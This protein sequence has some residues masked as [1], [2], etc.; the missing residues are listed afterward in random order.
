M[1]VA[2]S[3]DQEHKHYVQD[4]LHK[5]SVDLIQWIDQG[6]HLYVCGD[7]SRMAK[8]VHQALIEI[9]SRV[10]NVDAGAAELELKQ[11]KRAGRYQ[12]DIY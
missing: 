11:L 8:D 5:S 12:R 3:R 6:A 4:E 1:N 7:M 10:R 2:F 9:I